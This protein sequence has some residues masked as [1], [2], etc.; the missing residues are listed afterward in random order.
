[1]A[2]FSTGGIFLGRVQIR[3]KLHPRFLCGN[4]T[5]IQRPSE[6]RS[7]QEHAQQKTWSSNNPRSLTTIAKLVQKRSSLKGDA[8]VRRM[9]LTKQPPSKSIY[10]NQV[11]AGKFVTV[12]AKVGLQKS[13]T[14][15]Y[16]G[17]RSENQQIK[18][19]KLESG[20]AKDRKTEENA[21][22]YEKK[23][24]KTENS[25]TVDKISDTDTGFTQIPEIRKELKPGKERT[26]FEH[27][28]NSQVKR[29]R[30]EGERKVLR[31]KLSKRKNVKFD[32]QDGIPGFP[33]NQHEPAH[34]LKILNRMRNSKRKAR[35]DIN[36]TQSKGQEYHGERQTSFKKNYIYS[37]MKSSEKSPKLNNRDND[38]PQSL[39]NVS[40]DT[41]TVANVSDAEDR[42]TE[43]NLILQHMSGIERNNKTHQGASVGSDQK[44]KA[45]TGK[46]QNVNVQHQKY[47]FYLS[48]YL[49]VYLSVCLS[50]CLSLSLSIHL[51]IYL[52]ICLSV[53][54][55]VS[56]S[57]YIYLSIHPS[58]YLSIYLSV[59]LSVYLSIYLSVCLSVCL[60]VYL[61]I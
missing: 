16:H 26:M 52:S 1:M 50:I 6:A 42:V 25:D 60:S 35:N 44:I 40:D 48:I 47:P 49:S 5:F 36:I 45:S 10:A 34:A 24:D 8:T 4:N 41:E 7:V 53:F 15:A 19:E 20:L 55:S 12:A 38:A 30:D 28:G 31:R 9:P 13:I 23:S 27:N 39:Y 29:Q 37:A 32:T 14:S 56:V 54:L 57:V 18:W 51:S 11:H 17:R 61:S 59:C 46:E 33:Q 2:F 3:G 21:K 22:G 58:I 43:L